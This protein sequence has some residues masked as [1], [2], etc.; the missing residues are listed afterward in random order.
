MGQRPIL[1]R[2]SNGNH[3]ERGNGLKI[4]VLYRTRYRL[5]SS[6]SKHAKCQSTGQVG[7]I[8]IALIAFD[9]GERFLM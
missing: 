6:L 8:L 9:E 5:N 2:C 1:V 4:D 7:L 3:T